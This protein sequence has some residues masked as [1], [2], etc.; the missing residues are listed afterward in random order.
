MR[1]LINRRN[2]IEGIEERIDRLS[3]RASELLERE[4]AATAELE[5]LRRTPADQLGRLKRR[6]HKRAVGRGERHVEALRSKRSDLVQ[7]ELRA[8][9][10]S[11]E[12][13]SHRTR[14]RLDRELDRLAPVE[15]EWHR[16]REVFETLEQAVTVPALAELAGQWRG[17]LEIPEFPV[18]QRREYAK[19]FPERALLF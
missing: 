10:L 5:E 2:P 12:K 16:L 1:S 13:Q 8:I 3:E 19:P 7:E 18:S 9:M 14:E 17:T 15:A 4:Q 11:L 6:R